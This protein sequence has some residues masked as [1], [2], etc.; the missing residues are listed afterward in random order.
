LKTGFHFGILADL[1]LSEIHLPVSAFQEDS[2]KV[3]AIEIDFNGPFIPIFV[4][5]IKS[6]IISYNKCVC[7]GYRMTTKKTKVFLEAAAERTDI[8][9]K[10]G[11]Q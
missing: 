2:L 7:I 11:I 10:T 6:S 9:V 1:E 3:C 8:D 5:T 4:A